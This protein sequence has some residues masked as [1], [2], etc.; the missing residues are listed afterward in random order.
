M[1]RGRNGILFFP[2]KLSDRRAIGSYVRRNATR[3]STFYV[4]NVE[5]YL[6]QDGVWQAFCGNLA[7]LPIDE[8]SALVR[9]VRLDPLNPAVEG[10]ATRLSRMGSDV[11]ECTRQ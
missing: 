8:T 11:K 2:V 1:R 6:R 10:F 4:S 7:S 3:V 9:A 5:E